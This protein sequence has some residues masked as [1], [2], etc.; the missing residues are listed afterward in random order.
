MF[1]DEG[2]KPRQSFSLE[3]DAVGNEVLTSLSM[4]RPDHILC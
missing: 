3:T 2:I 4:L 1:A